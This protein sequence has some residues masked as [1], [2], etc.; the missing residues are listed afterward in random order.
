MEKSALAGK[1]DYVSSAQAMEILGVRKQTLYAYV[2]RGLIRS[3]KQPGRQERLYWRDDIERMEARSLARSGH[4]AVAASA[5]NWGEPIIP[6]SITEITPEGPRYRGR[7]AGDL[8]RMQ[9]PFETVAELLWTGMWNDQATNWPVIALK[10]ELKRLAQS[11]ASP[12][13]AEQLLEIFALVTLQLGLSRGSVKE[14]VHGGQT[15]VSAREI[16]QTLVGCFGL[17]TTK[18]AYVPM[19][20]GQTIVQGLMRALSLDATE[21]NYEAIQ[22]MMTLFADNELSPGALAVRVSASSGASLHA[23]ITSGICVSSGVQIGRFYDRVNDFLDDARTKAALMKKAYDLQKRD[24]S[25][26]GFVHPLY[27]HG[28]PRA[29]Y[30]FEVARRRASQ[31][32][33]LVAIY[34]FVEEMSTKHEI[35]P[36]HELAILALT[37]AMGLPRQIPGA[38]FV[39]ARIAGWVAHVQEQRLTGSL[40]R[41]RGRFVGATVTEAF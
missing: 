31:S 19:Q 38:L 18:A 7:L 6:T 16:I 13:A 2:S 25:V 21:E 34:G 37:R 12:D 29:K 40:L 22:S 39:L 32:K 15:L 4:G 36:R 20:D 9:V 28:D 27:P 10:P 14:R 1:K 35:Y 33:E 5:M 26:P 11:L 17:A 3:I 8:A 24:I 30:L 23:C 41:P